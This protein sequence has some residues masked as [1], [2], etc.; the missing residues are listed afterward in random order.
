M[1]NKK[2]F[3]LK[4][5]ADKND[6]KHRDITH[7]H[8]VGVVSNLVHP[9]FYG[10]TIDNTRK[11]TRLYA[12]EAI[13]LCFAAT[14]YQNFRIVEPAISAARQA[15]ITLPLMFFEPDSGIRILPSLIIFNK[16]PLNRISGKCCEFFNTEKMVAEVPEHASGVEIR[17]GA[18]FFHLLT[19]GNPGDIHKPFSFYPT[20]DLFFRFLKNLNIELTDMI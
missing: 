7:L 1:N 8:Q 3:K 17:V 16:Y 20:T 5:I 10:E 15:L 9:G 2:G 13:S 19:K 18:R 14:F 4:E 12:E 11:W 6:F